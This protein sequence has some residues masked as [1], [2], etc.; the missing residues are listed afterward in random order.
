MDANGGAVIFDGG[1]VWSGVHSSG[2]CRILQQ[3]DVFPT[4]AASL[5]FYPGRCL[6][7]LPRSLFRS[8]FYLYPT[9][10]LYSS[11]FMTST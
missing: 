4:L 1:R 10:R 11:G 5:R 3:R 6:V 7:P 2:T 9:L 8:G